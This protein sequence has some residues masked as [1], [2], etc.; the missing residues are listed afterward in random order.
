[1][2]IIIA[3]Q[4]ISPEVTV[5]GPMQWMGLAA[6]CGLTVRRVGMLGLSA[7]K[8]MAPT[9]KMETVTLI[10]LDRQIEFY[11][12]CALSV[13]NYKQKYFFL[14]MVS[15]AILHSGKYGT[16]K[17]RVRKYFRYRT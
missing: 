10:G 13:Q 4:C 14:N 3:L 6:C 2:W 12:L 15:R 1:V 17:C 9:V 7:R 8:M 11:M 16:L 5:K